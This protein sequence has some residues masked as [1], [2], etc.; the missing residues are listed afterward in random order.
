[1]RAPLGIVAVAFGRVPVTDAAQRAADLGF[2]HLDVADMALDALDEDA[3]DALA[4]PVGDRLSGMDMRDGCTS[5]APIER[6]G[7]DRF[8][9][10]VAM[11]RQHPGARL[12]PGPNTV[13]GSVARIEAMLAAVPELRLT[14]DT[15]HVATWG[16]DPVRVLRYAEHLQLR[17]AAKGRPQLHAD[18]GGDVDFGAVLRELERVRYRGRLSVEYFDLPDMGWPLDDPVAYSVALARHVRALPEWQA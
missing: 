10:T 16:E 9:E 15:G 6:R 7:E 13:L 17:Q 5:V 3:R 11:L 12:E 8:D 2:E 18:E 4:V 1:L 14:I